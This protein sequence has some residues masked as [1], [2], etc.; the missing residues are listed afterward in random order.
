M[1]SAL[2]FNSAACED[3][4]NRVRHLLADVDSVNKYFASVSFNHAYNE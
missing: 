1:W 2:K 4:N 3:G